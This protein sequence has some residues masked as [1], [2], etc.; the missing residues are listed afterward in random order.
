MLAH[1]N[2]FYFP[3]IVE[4]WKLNWLSICYLYITLDCDCGVSIC[5]CVINYVLCE[6]R[7]SELQYPVILS[8]RWQHLKCI[9][10]LPCLALF[11]WS[12]GQNDQMGVHYA[13][14]L[15]NAF[16]I[17]EIDELERRKSTLNKTCVMMIT[18]GFKKI[19]FSTFLV[20]NFR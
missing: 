3:R 17:N 12:W 4:F 18:V 9:L 10:M 15:S 16:L 8:L 13:C 2:L 7:F 11:L 5:L 1:I 14:F 20:C 6:L 19:A